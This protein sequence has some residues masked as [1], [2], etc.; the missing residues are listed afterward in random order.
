MRDIPDIEAVADAA[1]YGFRI[2][3]SEEIRLDADGIPLALASRNFRPAAPASEATTGSMP[4]PR[5][6]SLFSPALLLPV[7]LAAPAIIQAR[8][9]KDAE[10]ATPALTRRGALALAGGAIAG[11]ALAA[12]GAAQ[13]ASQL[14]CPPQVKAFVRG[15]AGG[16]F[17]SGDGALA[18]PSNTDYSGAVPDDG[19]G[20]RRLVITRAQTGE[21]YDQEFIQ[22]GSYNQA[23]LEAWNQFCKDG[24]GQVGNMDPNT[25]DLIWDIWKR[26]NTEVPFRLNSAYRSPAYNQKVGGAPNSNHM[27]GKATDLSHPSFAPREVHAAANSSPLIG[28][29]GSYSSFTHVDVGNKRYWNG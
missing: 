1:F 11:A 27:Y 23:A 24:S 5:R 10:A 21:T 28:G 15:G 3:H 2:G 6:R 14:L 8:R 9:G 4:A 7:A 13:A 16:A 18:S 12:P 17:S 22:N 20:L 26:L 25:L 19:P 29:L